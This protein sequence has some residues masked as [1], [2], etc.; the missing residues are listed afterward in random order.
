M[1]RM[2]IEYEIDDKDIKDNKDKD[3]KDIKDNKDKD[4][5]DIKDEKE[6]KYMYRTRRIWEVRE[7]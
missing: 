1:R 2:S 4:D 3:D 6:R 7:T 5:K